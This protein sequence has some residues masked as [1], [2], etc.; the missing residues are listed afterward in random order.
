ML[1]LAAAC[2]APIVV[3]LIRAQPATEPPHGQHA[4]G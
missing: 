2:V 4:S 1:V 3:D